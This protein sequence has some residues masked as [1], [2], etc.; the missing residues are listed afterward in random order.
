[1]SA[2]ALAA[3]LETEE[4]TFEVAQREL[5]QANQ[6]EP[7]SAASAY[8]EGQLSTWDGGFPPSDAGTADVVGD[9]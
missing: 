6:L 2:Q 9:P 8:Y 7:D 5:A 1:L 3:Q 4:V